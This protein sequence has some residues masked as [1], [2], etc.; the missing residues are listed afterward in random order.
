MNDIINLF[1][2]TE[3]K[4]VSEQYKELK[5]AVE[6]YERKHRL[7]EGDK[8][9]RMKTVLDEAKKTLALFES[10]YPKEKVLSEEVLS[11]DML[12]EETLNEMDFMADLKGPLKPNKNLN[13]LPRSLRKAMKRRKVKE[14]INESLL[15]ENTD[16]VLASEEVISILGDYRDDTLFNMSSETDDQAMLIEEIGNDIGKLRSKLRALVDT[17]SESEPQL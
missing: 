13:K 16:I 11:E 1:E 17:F 12:V 10:M 14:D 8:K 7:T 9:V 3:K 15:T 5:S 4:S 6:F 2:N